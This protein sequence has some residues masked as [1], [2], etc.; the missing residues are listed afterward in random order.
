MSSSKLFFMDAR[1][2]F[3]CSRASFIL[4]L[5]S[6]AWCVFSGMAHLLIQW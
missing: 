1:A 5:T 3:A 2:A 4:G 6:A